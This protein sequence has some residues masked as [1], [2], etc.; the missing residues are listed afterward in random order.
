[1]LLKNKYD[2]FYEDI[3]KFFYLLFT[4]NEDL[5]LNYKEIEKLWNTF[6]RK[7]LISYVDTNKNKKENDNCIIIIKKNYDT[8]KEIVKF[9][10]LGNKD[11][12]WWESTKNSI[13]LYFPQ[14]L[15]SK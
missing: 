6:C 15:D 3:F 2:K 1:M 7:Y 12:S 10:N 8:V 14:I 13:K 4:N 11:I 5:K 9:L